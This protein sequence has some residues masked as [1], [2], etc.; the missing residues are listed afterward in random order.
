M[1]MN[2]FR[3]N[4]LEICF[5]M[6]SR[7]LVDIMVNSISALFQNVCCGR[8]HREA[9]SDWLLLSNSWPRAA[10]L[11]QRGAEALW[12][13]ETGYRLWIVVLLKWADVSSLNILRCLLTQYTDKCF[14]IPICVTQAGRILLINLGTISVSMQ[15]L[16]KSQTIPVI[17]FSLQF[18][19]FLF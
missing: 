3:N 13:R 5:L 14:T 12:S 6:H 2:T 16:S 7:H 4:F 9:R 10:V 1:K 18:V 15:L 19:S 8:S 17:H 11:I